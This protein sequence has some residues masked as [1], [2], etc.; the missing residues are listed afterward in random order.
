MPS[1][2]RGR[3]AAGG[4]TYR[5]RTV[6]TNQIFI[7]QG[8]AVKISPDEVVVISGGSSAAEAYKYN[9]ADPDADPVELAAPT[10]EVGGRRFFKDVLGSVLT[11]FLP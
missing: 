7:W 6:R 4:G 10:T 8:C 2:A 9:M 3:A 11:G 5:Y 1:S